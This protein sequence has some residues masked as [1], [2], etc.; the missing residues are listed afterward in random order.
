MEFHFAG[1][2]FAFPVPSFLLS[3]QTYVYASCTVYRARQNGKLELTIIGVNPLK[4]GSVSTPRS[5]RVSIAWSVTS[6]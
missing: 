3:P 2:G 1:C 5:G 4:R 6:K